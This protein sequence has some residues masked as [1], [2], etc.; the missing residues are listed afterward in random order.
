MP[1]YLTFAGPVLSGTLVHV[2]SHALARAMEGEPF[3]DDDDFVNPGQKHSVPFK[4]KPTA[5]AAA[6]RAAAK[7]GRGKG[8]GA[9]KASKKA[10][11]KAT[12]VRELEGACLT[13]AW[14]TVLF[15]ERVCAQPQRRCLTA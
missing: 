9:A 5:V 1:H 12:P 6:E 2:N 14:Q 15:R 11:S 13:S 4:L 8:D 7:Q 10:S 3:N